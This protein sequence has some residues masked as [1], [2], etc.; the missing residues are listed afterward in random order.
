MSK[1]KENQPPKPPDSAIVLFGQA[2]EMLPKELEE[3]GLAG[4]VET[5]EIPG[6]PPNWKPLS[7]DDYM[8]GRVVDVRDLAVPSLQRAGQAEIRSTVA[9][10]D[11]AVPGGFRSLWLGADLKI[12]MRDSIGKVYAI[13]YDGETPMQGRN[14]MKTYRVYEVIPKQTTIPENTRNV[15]TV[16]SE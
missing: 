11:T 5:R 2:M 15:T 10:L 12:K 8:I 13:Y 1:P 16:G 9:V 7:K 14:P 3:M 4:K 6:V